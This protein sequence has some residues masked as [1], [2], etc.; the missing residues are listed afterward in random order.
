MRVIFIGDIVGRPGRFMVKTHLM[1]AIEKYKIDLSIA[2]IENASGGFGITKKNMKELINYKIDVMTSGNHIWD[3]K[4]VK[5]FIDDDYPLLRP[6]NY[7]PLLPGKGYCVKEIQNEKVA[8][9]NLMGIFTMPFVSNPFTMIEEKVEQLQ[10]ENIKNIII[11]F[12]AEAT[13][14]KRALMMFL[15]GKVSAIFGTH[16][17]IGTDDLE[18]VENT[19]YVSDVGLSGCNDG[20]IGM[21]AKAPIEKMLTGLSSR[22]D[23]DKNC[24]KIF[25]AIIFDIKDGKCEN[26][27]K[28]KAFNDGDITEIPAYIPSGSI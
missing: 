24:S 23:I 22:F 25:Q 21:D 27:F 4:E 19:A 8:I 6:L 20:V 9:I 7:S 11:D 1:K 17:H 12:H 14:E 28:I 13:A 26:A 15:K 18:I 3:K 10:K 5:D 16:T 2:N